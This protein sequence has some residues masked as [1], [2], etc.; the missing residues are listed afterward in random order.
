[1]APKLL[2]FA[3]FKGITPPLG[4]AYIPAYLRQYLGYDNTVVELSESGFFEDIR[5]HD[6]DIVGFS[7]VTRHYNQFLDLARRVKAELGVPAIL[8]GHH[9][10]P[11]P[12]TLPEEFDLAVLGEG[13][14]TMLEVMKLFLE[15][16]KFCPEKL[17]KINGIAFH[18]S[19]HVEITSPRELIEPLDGIPHP[20]RDLLDMDKYTQPVYHWS[21]ME[22]LRIA[23]IST[24]RGC[25]YN[26]V[27]CS[28]SVFWRGYRGFSAEYV[29]NELKTILED[30]PVDVIYIADDL[31]IGDRG[32]LREIVSLI[33][34]ESID[35]EVRF[36]ANARANLVDEEV[37]SLLKEM[38]LWHITFG[39]E[40]CSESVLKFLK[41]DTV[42]V[43]QNINA[44]ALSK[45][46][47]FDV[48]G[49]FM[50]GSPFETKE[51]MTKTYRFIENNPIDSFGIQVTTPLPGTELW[52]MAKKRGHVSDTMNFDALYDFNPITFIE[53]FDQYKH[54]LML[55]GISPEEFL[56]I[57]RK[58]QVL[59]LKRGRYNKLSFSDAFS[60]VFLRKCLREPG[61][62][63][64]ALKHLLAGSAFR[65]PRLWR[66][67]QRAKR[68]LGV[69]DK[70]WS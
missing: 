22:P 62:L 41:R 46:Y 36:W 70:S 65:F 49:N 32:R 3:L 52:K 56:K 38:N 40:S 6:P 51:D 47:G 15:N 1:M 54:F 42:T 30:Y 12:H 14:Q 25:P 9:I 20:A 18:E 69:K 44:L 58:F 8:G 39:F 4:V 45:K 37:C 10:T 68:V 13:E 11:I 61:F 26:C 5:K 55:D 33:K 34:E 23:S 19:D 28:A 66:A 27:Y 50:V 64:R 63:W 57:Y 43:E 21:F 48:E 17:R 16:G 24:S 59:Q 7:C 67:Y 60:F 35:K 2:I 53:N 31:F 29:V